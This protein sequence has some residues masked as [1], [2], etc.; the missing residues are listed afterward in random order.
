[1]EWANQSPQL[2]NA[3][4]QAAVVLFLASDDASYLNGHTLPVDAGAQVITTTNALMR[5]ANAIGQLGDFG[6]GQN[7]STNSERS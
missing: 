1:M 3:K 7:V 2:A 6:F 4:Q 5:Y